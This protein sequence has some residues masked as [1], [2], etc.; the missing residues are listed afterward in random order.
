MKKI[1]FGLLFFA[2][3]CRPGFSQDF[4]ETKSDHFIVYSKDVPEEFV[5]TVIDFSEKYYNEL[6]DKLGFTRYDYWT[7]DKRARIYVFPDQETYVRETRQP[8]WSSGVTSYE[9]KTI[10]TYPRA[11]GFFD[12]LLPHEIGHIVFREVIGSR[13]VPLWL[14]E[15]VASYLEQAKRIGADKI[16]FEAMNQNVFIPLDQLSAID[17]VE[18]RQRQD[19]NLYYAESVSLISYLIEKFGASSFN[20]FCKK[21]KEGKTI[22]DAL[23][24]AYFDIRN[25]H[26]LGELWEE[27]LRDKLKAKS[28]V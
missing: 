2:S 19:V 24:Y 28:Q 5:N 21:I 27:F 7:W 9:T 11:S 6:T 18:L 20:Q 12:S 8:A 13:H 14:E 10:W 15:G 4:T 22:D 16:V 17:G 25:A 1:L 3:V 26:R 23:S